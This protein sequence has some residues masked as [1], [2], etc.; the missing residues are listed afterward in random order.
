MLWSYLQRVLCGFGVIACAV[1]CG[2][3]SNTT[4]PESTPNSQPAF[5]ATR[6]ATARN[7]ADSIRG[8]IPEVT[9]VVDLT[10][11]NDTNNLIG[12][13]NGYVA[14]SVLVDSRLECSSVAPGVDCGATVEQ[15]PDENAAG[16]RADYIQATRES[17]P[18][19]GRE[20]TTARGNLLLR[21]SGLL[22][23]SQAK[24]YEAAFTG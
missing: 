7:A 14:A 6:S 22:K 9:D 13:P 5:I 15:W 3:P 24:A 19:L 2:I 20:W 16:K 10:E 11:D 8:A 21:I 4:A 1:S 12:R 18:V 23:P 17:A